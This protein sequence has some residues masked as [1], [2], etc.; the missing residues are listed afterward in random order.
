MQRNTFETILGAGVLV[1]AIGFGTLLYKSN[2][3]TS[4]DTYP[5]F[6]N[7]DRVDG[8][9]KG[10]EVKTAGITV[11]TVTESALDPKT[12]LARIKIELD[13][14]IQ[15]PSDSSLEITQEGLFGKRYLSLTLG[16]DDHIIAPNGNISFT[17]AGADLMQLL[18]KFMFSQKPEE[19]D[20][21]SQNN[22]NATTPNTTTPAHANDVP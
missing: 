21:H 15:L 6:A 12:Y 3:S 5:L 7:F 8:I 2:V 17:Q 20:R 14:S 16:S 11:G 4:T 9:R 1:S 19:D 22:Q 18:N 10:S 13:K